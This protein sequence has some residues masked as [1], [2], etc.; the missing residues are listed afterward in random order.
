MRT[1]P[2]SSAWKRS[3]HKRVLAQSEIHFAAVAADADVAAVAEPGI[4]QAP[5]YSTKAL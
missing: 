3:F 5:E 2:E 4:C 1:Q